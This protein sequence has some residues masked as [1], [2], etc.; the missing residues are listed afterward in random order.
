MRR[1]VNVGA[2]IIAVAV[3]LPAVRSADPARRVIKV[4][5]TR[6]DKV[7]GR[8]QY[9]PF[10][11]PPGTSRLAFSYKYDKASGTNAV[12]IGLFE[13]GPLDLGAPAFRGWSGGDREGATVGETEAT[14]GYWP[15]PLPAGQW[16]LV[17]GLYK[18]AEAGVD[19]EVAIETTG[20]ARAPAPAVVLPPRPPEPLRRGARWYSGGLHS[21]TVHSDGTL[22][23][24]GLSR[25]ARD[26]GL[27]FLAITD[28]NN[29]THQLERVPADGLLRIIGEEVTTPGGH[30]S[31]WGLG[32]VRDFIDFRAQPGDPRI[33]DLVRAATARGALFSINHPSASCAGCGWEHAVPEGVTG[34]EISNGNHGEMAKAVAMWDDL[35]KQGRRIVGVGSSDWHRG[36]RTIDVASVR[37]WASA[38]STSAILD[39]IR[40]GRVVVMAD[41]RT[42]PPLLVARAGRYRAGSGETLP[43]GGAS[44]V[45][46]DVTLPVALL[47]GRV[48]LIADGAV[49]A[50]SPAKTRVRFERPTGG[51]RYLRIHVFAADGSPQAV[52]NPVFL[53]RAR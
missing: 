6:Q 17:L 36:P 38:L 15:G 9:V 45:R 14:P 24:A 42:P 23:V 51:D 48:D 49:V 50:T 25:L 53:E 32:G 3:V 22:D 33:A 7:A 40:R 41:G 46:L 37:V 13:P 29:T 43:V 44:S 20:G 1:G 47:G 52:T 30:A 27:D 4:H 34:I 12:D 10:D 19:V 31:V 16:N 26:A 2:V 35:L 21:H 39:G 28:H 8:Y 11:V 18:V 5:Y